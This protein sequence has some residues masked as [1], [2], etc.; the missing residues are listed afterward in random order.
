ML[1][2]PMH[3]RDDTGYWSTAPENHE[4]IQASAP[5]DPLEEH[6]PL[7]PDIHYASDQLANFMFL[8]L[9]CPPN[10]Y[11]LKIHVVLGV[12]LIT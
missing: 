5:Q 6:C 4:H 11:R 3:P 8:C 7:E 9:I 1:L 10:L 2:R 12:D